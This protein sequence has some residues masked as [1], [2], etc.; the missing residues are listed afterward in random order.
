MNSKEQSVEVS[1]LQKRFTVG[2]AFVA[3]L[4]FG[5]GI[6]YITNK[7]PF[8]IYMMLTVTFI[9]GSSWVPMIR[10][11]RFRELLKSDTDAMI[12]S[13]LF[14]LVVMGALVAS[15]FTF[16][17]VFPALSTVIFVVSAS[18]FANKSLK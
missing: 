8:S 16:S 6:A 17:F 4:T 2:V 1:K 11:K 15:I 14:T 13:F 5:A 12:K 9:A 10:H 7:F 18:I 3:I